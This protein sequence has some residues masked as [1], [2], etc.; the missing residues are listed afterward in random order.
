M[1]A[2]YRLKCI[3]NVMV[4]FCLF[5]FLRPLIIIKIFLTIFKIK[6]VIKVFIV[7]FNNILL[8][9]IKR[10]Q[11]IPARKGLRSSSSS[12]L[13]V[14]AGRLKSAGD[15]GFAVAG[16]RVW[17]TLPPEVTSAATVEGFR[18]RLKTHLFSGLEVL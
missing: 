5:A 8:S 9:N 16:P 3:L 11:E 6:N 14:P 18:K 2:T 7:L 4:F 15:R 1:P 17:N 10:V 12:Q 13:I